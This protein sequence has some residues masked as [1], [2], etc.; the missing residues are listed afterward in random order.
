MCNIAHEQQFV[1][2]HTIRQTEM[3]ALLYSWVKNTPSVK[4]L[5]PQKKKML[6]PIFSQ[7]HNMLKCWSVTNLSHS[8][9]LL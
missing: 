5:C 3:C 4:T 7:E 8:F 6:L 9:S 1:V 2:T